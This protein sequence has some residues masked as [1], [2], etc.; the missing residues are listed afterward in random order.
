MKIDFTKSAPDAQV[1]EYAHLTDAG[2][3]LRS[4]ESV[5]L[6]PGERKLTATGVAVAI[7][8]GYAGFITPRSGMANKTG[9]TVLNTPGLIDSGYRGELFVNL[10][11]HGY[12][13]VSIEAGAKIAQLVIQEVVQVSFNEVETLNESDR[14]SNGH[15]ST[16][17]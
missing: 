11:N 8:E 12:E 13:T 5:T 10:I 2:A 1:P 4:T 3:D 16:G 17:L 9:V 14:G 7:P 6:E 15:G